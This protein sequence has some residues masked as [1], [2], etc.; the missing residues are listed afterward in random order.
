LA[1]RAPRVGSDLRFDAELA[2][3]PERTS[4]DRGLRDIEVERELTA[5]A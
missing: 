5:A 1:E 4:R 3:Q 2:Q